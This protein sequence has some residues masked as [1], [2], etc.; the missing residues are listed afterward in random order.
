[1]KRHEKFMRERE[2]T[3]DEATEN[4]T[5]RVRD[6]RALSTLIGEAPAFLKAM[7]HLGAVAHSDGTVLITGETGTGKELVARHPLSERSCGVPFRRGQLW[8]PAG[9]LAGERT[10]RPRALGLHRRQGRAAGAGRPGGTGHHE[11]RLKPP[12]E[13]R[14]PIRP[15]GAPP[16]Y[17]AFP[18]TFSNGTP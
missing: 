13:R 15:V 14:L 6:T 10:L 4:V 16:R 1:M 5:R 8:L 2:G 9:Y 17:R 7:S 3:V 11:L 12:A 18:V